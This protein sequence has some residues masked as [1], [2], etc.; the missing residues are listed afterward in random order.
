MH[1]GLAP[2]A[3]FLLQN[4]LAP[5]TRKGYSKA[6]AN[7]KYF[8]KSHG[9]APFLGSLKT[10]TH[11]IASLLPTVKHS[12]ILPQCTPQPLPRT[13]PIPRETQRPNRREHPTW[14]K[15]TI[16]STHKGTPPS[17]KRH[18]HPDRPSAQYHR[19]RRPQYTRSPLLWVRWI[20]PCRGIYVG[21]MESSSISSTPSFSQTCNLQQWNCDTTSPV[22]QNRPLCH[23]H[24]YLSPKIPHR[25][26]LPCSC[27]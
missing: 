23:R 9:Y 10:I 6:V 14:R 20:P 27:P 13:W 26:D 5:S 19:C 11:W 15:A 25:T 18:P 4:S 21:K 1:L 3:F 16:Q 24:R 7:Y 17:Y 2:E 12:T 8:A 22:F